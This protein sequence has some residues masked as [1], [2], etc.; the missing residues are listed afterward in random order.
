MSFIQNAFV[1]TCVF[2]FWLNVEKSTISDE[3]RGSYTEVYRATGFPKYSLMTFILEGRKLPEF[4]SI[5]GTV[6]IAC[7]ISYL[8]MPFS[9]LETIGLLFVFFFRGV[10][11]V[12]VLVATPE[13]RYW[14][15]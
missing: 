15:H 1:Y 8:I 5:A 11:Y 3:I 9:L 6:Y 12:D 10:E 2:N 13:M 14:A 7:N 4:T